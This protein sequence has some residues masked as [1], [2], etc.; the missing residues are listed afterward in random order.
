MFIDALYFDARIPNPKKTATI[1]YPDDRTLP[2][3]MSH[4]NLQQI[5][6]AK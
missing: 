5:L 2:R 4:T 3:R 1:T 6:Y